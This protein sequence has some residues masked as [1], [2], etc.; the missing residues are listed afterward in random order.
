[1]TD[2]LRKRNESAETRVLAGDGDSLFARR[3]A[4][5]VAV[6]LSGQAVYFVQAV[7]ANLVKIGWVRNSERFDYR[8]S[9]LESDCP[10][11]VK[12]LHLQ[13]AA[14]RSDEWQAHKLFAAVRHH[15]EWFRIEGDLKRFLQ[16]CAVDAARAADV[17]GAGLREKVLTLKI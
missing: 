3:V 13:R 1:M 6:D 14:S 15:G 5:V 7:G 8:F 4:P 16:L 10:Y 12:L 2:W 9:R 17:L 11:P